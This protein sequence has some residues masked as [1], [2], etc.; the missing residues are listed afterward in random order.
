MAKK[1]QQESLFSFF[2]LSL[3]CLYSC[4]NLNLSSKSDII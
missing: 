1:T 4:F 3:L 2:L